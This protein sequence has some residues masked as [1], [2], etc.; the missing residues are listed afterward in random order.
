MK[1][2]SL[3]SYVLIHRYP[4]H[5]CQN[6]YCYQNINFAF[7]WYFQRDYQDM[8]D[9]EQKKRWQMWECSGKKP[10][11]KP[12][13][14]MIWSKQSLQTS[15]QTYVWHLHLNYLSRIIFQIINIFTGISYSVLFIYSMK[16]YQPC[17]TDR[18]SKDLQNLFSRF[19][20]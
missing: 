7:Y 13:D 10:I 16:L 4:S 3:T 6:K 2:I 14:C 19:K 8:T 18:W 9:L 20:M 5:H 11:R 1:S 12:F 17:K 15:I